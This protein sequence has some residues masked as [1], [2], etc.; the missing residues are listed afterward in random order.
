MCLDAR[1]KQVACKS[2]AIVD[3]KYVVIKIGNIDLQ[4]GLQS[5]EK[6]LEFNV[7]RNYHVFDK[8]MS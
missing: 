8:N 5:I 2:K 1:H 4:L 3:S 7:I 6:E